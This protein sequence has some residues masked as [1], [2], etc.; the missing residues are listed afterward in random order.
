[1]YIHVH[2][3]GVVMVFLWGLFVYLHVFKYFHHFLSLIYFSLICM[4]DYE[5]ISELLWLK[6]LCVFRGLQPMAL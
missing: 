2:I 1:M 4:G 6:R 5:L 3:H